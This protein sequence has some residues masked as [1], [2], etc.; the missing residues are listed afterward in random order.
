MAFQKIHY[1]P[2]DCKS[3]Y[4]TEAKKLE[5]LDTNSPLNMTTDMKNDG[6]LSTRSGF[7]FQSVMRE[8]ASQARQRLS[9]GFK[10]PLQ[11]RM[12][13]SGAVYDDNEGNPFQSK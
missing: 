5:P 2:K 1:V 3:S 9:I 6:N 8:R 13:I 12:L 11:R 4:I 7:A 10:T